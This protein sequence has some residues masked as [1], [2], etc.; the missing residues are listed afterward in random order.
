MGDFTCF[1][2]IRVAT[3]NDREREAELTEVDE[4]K[5]ECEGD[6]GDGEPCDDKGSLNQRNL[7]HDNAEDSIR[8]LAKKGVN[9]L[10]DALGGY[11]SLRSSLSIHAHTGES[12]EEEGCDQGAEQERRFSRHRRFFYVRV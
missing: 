11:D 4:F 1:I 6:R 3:A 9:L 5:V 8:N 2:R 10:I 7:P 12:S